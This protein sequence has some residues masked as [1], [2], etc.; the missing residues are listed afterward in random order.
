MVLLCLRP[1]PIDHI[2]PS[3]GELLYNRKL[4]GNLPVKCPNNASQKEKI[5]T[6]L[7]QRQSYQKSQHD[8]HIR[9]LPNIP[10]GQRVRVYDPNSS[11]WSPVVVTQRCVEPRS[12]IV[13]T[14][15]GKS[16]R[17]NLKHLRKDKS[18]ATLNLETSAST[19]AI[20]PESNG[21]SAVSTTTKYSFMEQTSTAITKGRPVP[22]TPHKTPYTHHGT[23]KT[24]K[25]GRLIRPSGKFN[26]DENSS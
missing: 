18:A 2:I 15:S 12:Y 20:S 24:S 1:T 7:Y 8:Q 19:S 14:S 16:L 26:Y 5:A 13:Q 4:V 6:R 17:R 10:E 23:K 22:D 9:D 21:E 11:K 25:S 3:L